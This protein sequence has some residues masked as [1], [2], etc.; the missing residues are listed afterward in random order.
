MELNRMGSQGNREEARDV[1]IFVRHIKRHTRDKRL[2]NGE[3]CGELSHLEA[4]LELILSSLMCYE[5]QVFEHDSDDDMCF[6]IVSVVI[7]FVVASCES[8]WCVEVW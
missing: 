4:S 5:C 8:V 6:S 2:K 7:G 1:R 3:M